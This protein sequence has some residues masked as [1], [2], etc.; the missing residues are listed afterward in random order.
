MALCLL[1]ALSELRG[2]SGSVR[3]AAVGLTQQL[4]ERGDGAL[5]RAG[6]ALC[7]SR[8]RQHGPRVA[9]VPGHTR[10]SSDGDPA[11]LIP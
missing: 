11:L 1:V 2:V 5:Q 10:S 9:L 6:L 4:V 7:W 3:L 8:A